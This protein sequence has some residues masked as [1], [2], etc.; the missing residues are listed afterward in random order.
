V[1]PTVGCLSYGAASCHWRIEYEGALYHLFSRGNNQIGNLLG[2]THSAVSRRVA[3]T[4][5]KMA[6]EPNFN[7]RIKAI[8]SQIKP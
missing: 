8:K 3:I 4:R 6:L 7:E 1:A 2:L 5:K